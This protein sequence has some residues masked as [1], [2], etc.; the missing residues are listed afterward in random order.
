MRLPTADLEEAVVFSEWR[1][2]RHTSARS[3]ERTAELMAAL[4]HRPSELRFPC[5][6]SSAPRAKE[7]R[8][9]TPQPR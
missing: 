2:L 8:P 9:P 3:L 4:G 7:P 6:G 1:R 5:W